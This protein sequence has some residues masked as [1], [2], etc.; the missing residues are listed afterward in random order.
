MTLLRRAP[1]EVYRVYGE[2]EFWANTER[3][4][5]AANED[6][7]TSPQ[8]DGRSALRRVVALSALLTALGA[9]GGVLVLTRAPALRSSARQLAVTASFASS[10]H[11]WQTRQPLP[12]DTHTN[13][14]KARGVGRSGQAPGAHRHTPTSP[15]LASTP[16]DSASTAADPQGA[17][18]ETATAVPSG[19]TR[20]AVRVQVSDGVQPRAVAA[21]SAPPVS[22]EQSEFG[23]ER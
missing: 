22:R 7:V 23:F 4:L 8:R 11:I 2:D 10:T 1:R 3:E 18:A 20:A 5:Q 13:V 14:V 12:V 15:S 21:V 9:V 16:A 19:E 17:S 6:Q